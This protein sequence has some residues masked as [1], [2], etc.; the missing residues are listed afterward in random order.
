MLLGLHHPVKVWPKGHAVSMIFVGFKVSKSSCRRMPE[1]VHGLNRFEPCPPI[2]HGGTL[3]NLVAGN[4]RK[5][6][7][8]C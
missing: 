8:E 4:F 2:Y 1:G 7:D 6:G 5:F 3:F